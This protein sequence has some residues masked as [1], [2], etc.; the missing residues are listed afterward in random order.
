M[1]RLG[2][3]ISDNIKAKYSGIALVVLLGIAAMAISQKYSGP[4]ML[5]AILIGLSLHPAYE[6]VKLQSGI[7]WC[8]RPLLLIGVALLGFRVDFHDFIAL[9]F[10]SPLITIACLLFTISFG[11]VLSKVIDVPNR[12]GIL[13]SGAVAI[14][15]V[16]AA[17]AISS[18]LPKSESRERD[19]TL[20]VAGVTAISTLAMIIYPVLSEWLNHSDFQAGLFLGASIHDVAQVVGAGYS[21][22]NDAGNNATLVK[23]IRV[24]ALLP[25][26]LTISLIFRKQK[27]QVEGQQRVS[28]LPPFLIA[29]IIIA[30]LNSYHIFS[31][32]VQML[33]TEASKYCLIISLVAIGLKT[34]LK[35]MSTVGKSPLIL[36]ITV[37]LMLALFSLMLI[38]FF[39]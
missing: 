5:F 18:A 12:L 14:C 35:G 26:V 25:V 32:Y 27:S 24:S 2:L 16:S 8:A 20:T 7:D 38:H 39:A 21:I 19:L 22:S 36:L 6:S 13:I 34:D 15:G 33:G 28:L 9:G 23:L 17:V 3:N 29:Y 37:T 31:P 30:A 10:I 1:Q 11:I 4:V